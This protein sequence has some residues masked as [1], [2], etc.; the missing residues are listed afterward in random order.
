[1]AKAARPKKLKKLADGWAGF[2][3]RLRYAITE[4][5]RQ[6]EERGDEL[7]QNDIAATA[8][9]DSGQLTKI[10]SGERTKGLTVNT[11]LWLAKALDVRP[12]WLMTGE[13]P[14]GLANQ[15]H[16]TVAREDEQGP[17]STTA[18]AATTDD[19]GLTAAR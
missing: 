5:Q 3:G 15:P 16:Q 14:S 10:A 12:I 2:A 17:A 7:T 6:A 1:M 4:R 9:V 19:T 13:E 8:N 18:G 11:L